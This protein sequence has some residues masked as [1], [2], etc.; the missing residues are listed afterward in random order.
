VDDHRRFEFYRTCFTLRRNN[1]KTSRSRIARCTHRTG[2][3]VPEV[4]KAASQ[5]SRTRRHNPKQTDNYKSSCLHNVQNA[6][7]RGGKQHTRNRLL[8]HPANPTRLACSCSP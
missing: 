8:Q 3:L 6:V 4:L 7:K 2:F 5:R 1:T